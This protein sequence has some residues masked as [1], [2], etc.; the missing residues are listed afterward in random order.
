MKILVGK[1]VKSQGIKGEVKIDCYLDDSALLKNVK[2][3]F[4]E[5]TQKEV[6]SIRTDG[7]FCY[8]S[9]IDVNDRNKADL[10]KDWLVF[11]NKSDIELKNDSYFIEDLCGCEFFLSNGD[12]VGKVS[13][14]LQNGSADVFVL[15]SSKGEVLFPWLKK[16]QLQ[17]DLINKKIIAN[18]TVFNE[19]ACYED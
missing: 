1:I 2:Q 6:R 5:K 14:I 4:L 9:F 11:A 3:L 10:Y 18:E 12:Y 17:I 13:E 15:K 16:L 19:V 7:R 8:V